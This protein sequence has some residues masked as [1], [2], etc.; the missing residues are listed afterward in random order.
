MKMGHD[1][2]KT[3]H[4]FRHLLGTLIAVAAT[5]ISTLG[6]AGPNQAPVATLTSPAAGAKY[7]APASILIAVRKIARAVSYVIARMLTAGTV[8]PL[9]LPWPRAR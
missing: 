7:N 6:Y 3:T 9:I 1:N 4:L 2:M 8:K 5:A